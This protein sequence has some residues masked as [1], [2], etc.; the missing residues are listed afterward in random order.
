MWCRGY[1]ARG[2]SL[3][4]FSELSWSK[5]VAKHTSGADGLREFPNTTVG[6]FTADAGK[7]TTQS[8]PE[9]EE[10]RRCVLNY[11]GTECREIHW[12]LIR[13]AMS[14]VAQLAVSPLQ[15]ILGLGSEY[16]MNRPG[17]L[18]GNWEWRVLPAQVTDKIGERLR[19]VTAMCDRL[20]ILGVGAVLFSLVEIEKY[21]LRTNMK[22]NTRFAKLSIC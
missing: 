3:C 9:V 2:V 6:W 21:V 14:S 12:D 17:T 8:K 15:D 1:R 20:P 4:G 13:L 16:R 5:L 11:I 10:E 22:A 19:D 7:E 18:K